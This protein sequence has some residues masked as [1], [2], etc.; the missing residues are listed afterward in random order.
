MQSFK[1]MIEVLRSDSMGILLKVI[2][3]DH[4]E[5]GPEYMVNKENVLASL[6]K[7]TVHKTCVERFGQASA[8]VVQLLYRKKLQVRLI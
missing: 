7:S 3:S 5:K 2:G 6:Q 1:K 8:R 4:F